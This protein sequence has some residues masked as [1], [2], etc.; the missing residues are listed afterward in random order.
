MNRKP[1]EIGDRITWNV[2]GCQYFGRVGAI[3]GE[4]ENAFYYTGD[5]IVYVEERGQVSSGRTA[6][7]TPNGGWQYA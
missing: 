3:I 2:C 7:V 4:A 6:I 5:M 1:P